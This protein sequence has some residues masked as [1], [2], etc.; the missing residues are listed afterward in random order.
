[1]QKPPC[2]TNEP[3]F[4]E[5]RMVP[6]VW[7]GQR[8]AEE[9]GRELPDE[10]V[11]ESWEIHGDLKVSGTDRTLDQLVEEFG[12]ELLGSRVSAAAGFPL[13]TKWLDCRAWLSV[14]VHPDD[15]LAR[16]FTGDSKARGKTEAWYVH[17]ASDDAE[18]IHGLREGVKPAEVGGLDDEAILGLLRRIRPTEGQM[19]FTPAGQVHALG[20]GNLIYEVQQSCDL[21]YR[22]YDWGRDREIHPEKA[23][24][25]VKRS[26][27]TSATVS[28]NSLQCEY[29]RMELFQ[30]R[31]QWEVSSDSFQIV[32][33]TTE[34]KLSWANG[35]RQLSAGQS[36]LLPAGLGQV[37]LEGVFLKVSIP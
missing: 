21:T 3:I 33:T 8:L 17:K 13:L 22:F 5:P 28:P 24:E 27:P 31:E 32:A 23:S 11:G 26:V 25:C 9:F 16:E 18:L 30:G 36:V 7:G 1:V 6:R 19:L 10:A 15:A 2:V 34:S 29:F 37:K 4:V 12:Q 35:S 20:P 14:Q